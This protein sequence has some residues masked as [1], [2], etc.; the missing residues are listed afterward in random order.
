MN[1]HLHELCD[2]PHVG[3]APRW[4]EPHCAECGAMLTA[5]APADDWLKPMLCETC[6]ERAAVSAGLCAVCL[7]YELRRKGAHV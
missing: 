1:V 4:H 3:A 7:P 2:Q 5:D 6:G